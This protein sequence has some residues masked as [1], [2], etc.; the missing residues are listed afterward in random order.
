[1]NTGSS[2]QFGGYYGVVPEVLVGEFHHYHNVLWISG[3][4]H[5]SAGTVILCKQSAQS[6]PQLQTF[7][8]GLDSCLR[9]FIH[10]DLVRP[11]SRKTF[12]GPLARGVN[13]HLRAEILQACGVIQRVHGPQTELHVAFGVQSTKR[14]PDYLAVIVDI[15]VMI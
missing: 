1:M 9:I 7:P 12:G 13:P 8:D 10:D 15:H 6:G 3:I 2:M 11:R 5:L 4:S 14:L